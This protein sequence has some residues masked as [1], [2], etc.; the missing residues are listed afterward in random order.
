M[1]VEGYKRNTPTTSQRTRYYVLLPH[2][3]ITEW[4]C[5]VWPKIDERSTFI[6]HT[7]GHHTL[8]HTQQRRPCQPVRINLHKLKPQNGSDQL[9]HLPTA[10]VAAADVSIR[11]YV[12]PKLWPCFG[13]LTSACIFLVLVSNTGR[14]YMKKQWNVGNIIMCRLGLVSQSKVTNLRRPRI[15][16]IRR[17]WDGKNQ[18]RYKLCSR[19]INLTGSLIRELFCT[20]FWRSSPNLLDAVPSSM[21]SSS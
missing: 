8:L 18:R 10:A 11:V 9:L 5:R 16:L 2:L 17:N 4:W 19:R 13:I 1:R 15:K 21:S 12:Q 14:L 6:S 20:F 7:T 3:N